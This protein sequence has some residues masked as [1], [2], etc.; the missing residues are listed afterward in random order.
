M[1]VCEALRDW[2][3]GGNLEHVDGGGDGDPAG[4]MLGGTSLWQGIESP[5]GISPGF[6]RTGESQGA[7][8]LR[9]PCGRGHLPPVGTVMPSDDTH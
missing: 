5:Q 7:T 9:A 3:W 1:S 6:A 8:F 4:V 2:V